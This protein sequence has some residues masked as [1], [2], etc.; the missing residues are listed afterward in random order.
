MITIRRKPSPSQIRRRKCIGIAQGSRIGRG[1]RLSPC[2][3][4]AQGG[5]L[6]AMLALS[7]LLVL[8]LAGPQTKAEEPAEKFVAAL[9]ENGYFDVALEYL[10]GAATD[11]LVA[12][13][14]RDQVP[15]AK[16]KVLILSLASEQNAVRRET[17]LNEADRLL[18]QYSQQL[19]DPDQSLEVLEIS[20]NIKIKRA[21]SNISQSKNSRLIQSDRQTLLEKAQ[22][23]LTPARQQY[24]QAR[25]SL[26]SR[27]EN[28][29]VDPEA[30]KSLA[31]KKRLQESYIRV[32]TKLPLVTE[33]IAD[34]LPAGSAEQ[35]QAYRQA[36]EENKDI[37][38]DYSSRG[39]VFVFEASI[40]GARAAQ[41]SG[42]HKTAL[43]MLNNVFLL[44]DGAAENRL[45]KDAMLVA[46][47]SWNN[48]T[49]YPY[50]QVVQLLTKPI[51]QLNRN[52]LRNPSCQQ[53][54]LEFGKAQLLMADSLKSQGG[55]KNAAKAR[56]LNR[57]SGI[58]VR[59]LARTPGPYRD[60]ALALIEQHNL[61]FSQQ[62][63]QEE[64]AEIKTFSDAKERGTE[65]ITEIVDLNAEITDAQRKLSIDN[66][67]DKNELQLLI[68]QN[69]QALTSKISAAL[70]I[71]ETALSLTDDMTTRE[72]INYVH[73]QRAICYF[74]Q[75][76]PLESAVI[77]EFLLDRY[78][79]VQWTKQASAY[80][81]NGYAALLESAPKGDRKFEIGKL[82]STC[83]EICDRWSGSDEAS[84]A[85]SKLT[86]IA[87]KNGDT[88]TAEEFFDQISNSWPAKHPLA[89]AL[90]QRLWFDYQRQTEP[91]QDRSKLAKIEN[92][93]TASI[94]AAGSD[95]GYPTANSALTLAS[96]LLQQD[97]FDEALVQLESSSVAPLKLIRQNHASISDPRYADRYRRNAYLTA[98]KT[99][100]GVMGNG[101]DFNAMI[102]KATETIGLLKAEF[103]AS[104]D[105][106]AMEK[107]GAIYKSVARGL[108]T[109]FESLATPDQRR[110]FAI[111]L[112]K[113][114]GTIEQ[115]SNDAPTVLWTGS[116]LLDVAASLSMEGAAQAEVSPLYAQAISALDRAE[117]IGIND[118]K[119][120]LTLAQQRAL[121]LR[122]SGK[123]QAS[124][125]A[126]VE[127]L[128]VN[129]AVNLQIDAAET[130]QMWG[131]TE[132]NK[133]AYAKA[134]MGTGR[135]KDGKREK[136]A[137]WGWR[138]LV[139]VTRGK[140]KFN[141][142][143][144]TSLYN[145]VKSRFEYGVLDS[146]K[147]AIASSL[148]ELEKSFQR[149]PFLKTG[150]WAKK[151]DDLV[152]E[153]KEKL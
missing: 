53:L 60:D 116:T 51:G 65:L 153:I 85:A 113:F 81:V 122:G 139:Q 115:Q 56:E 120:K 82:K 118:S 112:A 103:Q 131:K 30:P 1:V 24:Q 61:S 44:G 125:N 49:P 25:Q 94:R 75:S 138:K 79:T 88:T 107:L 47:N 146:N 55:G 39:A 117:K 147:K 140:E 141:A 99:Y 8:A 101:G 26:R 40:N 151:F 10:D 149:F 5:R 119:L 145:S 133:T 59:K 23:L 17:K 90:G 77:A 114:M 132:S 91:S 73:Y 70:Q 37:Y 43:A 136:N 2:S 35:K 16:A 36:V 7:A 11:D 52:E 41:K 68:D 135:Y 32:R 80:I 45:K 123:Y 20:A 33:L 95:F 83:R 69:S 124:V 110:M 142:I 57:E 38:A 34:T 127:L 3:P 109:Q 144:R 76:K 129:S 58:L 96:L 108:K 46:V 6:L 54:Q 100:L 28:F 84:R 19:S 66:G 87:L 4:S 148:S 12:Q 14:Y 50:E 48:Q 31:Q 86:E 137:V 21:E 74:F 64:V 72:S 143:Y 111:G 71:Y 27:I 13:D 29:Q 78:P 42:D 130:L 92:M 126:F 152:A 89:A 63:D 22:T 106:Q 67:Q 105:P 150:P 9:T 134:M 18:S 93:L 15:F 97:R 62:P 128:K 104:N 98:I 102:D 121:A